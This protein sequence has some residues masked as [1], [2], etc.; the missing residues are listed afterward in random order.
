MHEPHARRGW[1]AAATLVSLLLLWEVAARPG[2]PQAVLP[3]PS[4]IVAALW[5]YR[6]LF[7][8]HAL[9][10]LLEALGGLIIALLLAFATATISALSLTG[11][12]IVTPLVLAQQTVP[13]LAIGPLIAPLMGNGPFAIML[14][15]AW[16]C[17]FPA[18]TA[19][20]LG[21]LRVR[22]E[23]IAVFRVAGAS[24]WQTYRF[25]RLPGA[26]LSLVTGVRAAA[27]LALIGAI[28]AEYGGAQ[29]GLGALIMQHVSDD[30]ALPAMAV[31]ALVLLCSSL[32]LLFTWGA[33]AAA[34]AALRKQITDGA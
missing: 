14:I 34:R 19:F 26:A 6:E 4:T 12:R 8:P 33:T 15:A 7:A 31:F 29:R 32:G 10:T 27:G 13:L 17:W 11:H 22:A 21:F 30:R 20:T 9:A 24:R 28:V 5:D 2:G 1:I 23:W 18:V 25:L 3:P 16:L